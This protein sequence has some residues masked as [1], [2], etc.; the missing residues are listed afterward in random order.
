MALPLSAFASVFIPWCMQRPLEADLA[1]AAQVLEA[2]L[3]GRVLLDRV[4]DNLQWS[5][6]AC[7]SSQFGADMVVPTP[8]LSIFLPSWC[9]S[10]SSSAPLT[11]A[12]GPQ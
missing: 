8:A 10:W 9:R 12:P 2:T 6:S 7:F 11:A 1:H 5:S 3:D 4:R